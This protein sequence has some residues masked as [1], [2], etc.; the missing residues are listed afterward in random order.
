MSHRHA[1]TPGQTVGPFFGYAL[2]FV[3]GEYLVPLGHPD[4][5]RL[6]GRV[7]DGAD[8]P[9]PD[10]LVEIW[11]ADADGAIPKQ[12]GSL[13]RDGYTFTGWGRCATDR[14]GRYS[15]TTVLPGPTSSGRA[16]IV[17]ATLFA[18]GLL[19][20]LTTRIYL[21]DGQHTAA[22][23]SD[24]LLC[25]LPPQERSAL[26]AERTGREY[27]FDFRLQGPQATPFLQYRAGSASRR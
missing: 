22:V 14:L 18:R 12:A 15:F 10:A 26:I 16:P 24:P 21:D 25:S 17:A 7:L 19:D 9:V 1:D 11:Q 13:H 6:T 5:I 20:R 3:G 8:Q 2:P 4:A 23:S 27:H